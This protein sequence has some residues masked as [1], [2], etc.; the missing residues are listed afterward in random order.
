MPNSHTA[1]VTY[2]EC[3]DGG[4]LN[5]WKQKRE[6]PVESLL[7]FSHCV[8]TLSLIQTSKQSFVVGIMICFLGWGN[9]VWRELLKV[10]PGRICLESRGPFHS[11]LWHGKVASLWSLFWPFTVI[12]KV[13]NS[14]LTPFL[15]CCLFARSFTRSGCVTLRKN[16]LSFL[17]FFFVGNSHIGNLP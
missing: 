4:R 15:S 7:H 16:S 3:I 1:R 9:L 14:L 11:A 10:H 17:L 2:S 12:S 5:H 13:T 6:N 8:K